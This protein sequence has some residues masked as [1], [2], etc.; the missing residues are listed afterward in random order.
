MSAGLQDITLE[1]K[2]GFIYIETDMEC[3]KTKTQLPS[4]QRQVLMESAVQLSAFRSHYVIALNETQCWR[5]W[6]ARRSQS[7]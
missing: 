5:P 1:K 6:S 2:A 3:K 7:V 4:C